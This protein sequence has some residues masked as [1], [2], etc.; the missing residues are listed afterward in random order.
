MGMAEETNNGQNRDIQKRKKPDKMTGFILMLM[1]DGKVEHMCVKQEIPEG[2]L[3]R[4]TYF[5]LS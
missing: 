4:F 2:T 1:L 5:L 3:E